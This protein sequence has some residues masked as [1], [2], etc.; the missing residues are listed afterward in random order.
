[1]YPSCKRLSDGLYPSSDCRHYYQCKDERTIRVLSC[2]KSKS[3]GAQL[4]FNFITKRCDDI[5]NVSFN[6]GGYAIP[7]DIYSK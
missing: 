1:M 7:I 4:K 5:E 3:T 2:P 6:C